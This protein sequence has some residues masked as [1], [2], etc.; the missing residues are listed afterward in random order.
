MISSPGFR[1]E[2]KTASTA[3]ET[4]IVTKISFL[5]RMMMKVDADKKAVSDERR[6]ER[7][8]VI[9]VYLVAAAALG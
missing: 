3:S 6:T 2:R 4:P 7:L 1:I 5:H 9:T 8:C